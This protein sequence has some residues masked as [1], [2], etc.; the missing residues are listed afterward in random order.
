MICWMFFKAFLQVFLCSRIWFTHGHS[1]WCRYF[2]ISM[3][4]HRIEGKCFWCIEGMVQ[5]LAIL[6]IFWIFFLTSSLYYLL[7]FWD[8]MTL[9]DKFWYGESLWE[10]TERIIAILFLWFAWFILFLSMLFLLLLFNRFFWAG[11]IWIINDVLFNFSLLK[12]HSFIISFMFFQREFWSLLFFFFFKNLL[13]NHGWLHWAEGI[14]WIYFIFFHIFLWRFYCLHCL[15]IILRWSNSLTIDLLLILSIFRTVIFLS[16]FWSLP[17]TITFLIS[18]AICIIFRSL[19]DH[20]T[21]FFH[22]NFTSLFNI[23]NFLLH[24]RFLIII[25]RFLLIFIRIDEPD[26]HVIFNKSFMN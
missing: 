2:S 8:I 11:V 26:K 9:N 4:N 19:V 22:L 14:G 21:T 24:F 15:M 1:R 23:S 6:F 7:S 3:W 13:L 20:W 16:I 25:R 10:I 17:R 5:V 12:L 18:S